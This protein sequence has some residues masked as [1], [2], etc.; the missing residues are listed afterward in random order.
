MFGP[1]PRAPPPINNMPNTPI[2]PVPCN[3]HPTAAEEWHYCAGQSSTREKKLGCEGQCQEEAFKQIFMEGK[4]QRAHKGIQSL[5][6]NR[7]KMKEEKE[8]A[9]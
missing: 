3:A 7:D 6:E 2:Q 4:A 1:L 9:I 5:C 8:K